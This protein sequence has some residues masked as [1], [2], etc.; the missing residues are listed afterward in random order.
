MQQ[1]S[2]CVNLNEKRIV[3]NKDLNFVPIQAVFFVIYS[4]ILVL[5]NNLKINRVSSSTERSIANI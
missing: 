4:S 2:L 3:F 5:K 1:N